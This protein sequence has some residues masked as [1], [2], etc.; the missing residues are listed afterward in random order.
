MN[1]Y[2]LFAFSGLLSFFAITSC[3]KTETIVRIETRID[4]LQVVAKDTTFSMNIVNW[5]YFG[6][7]NQSFL[8]AGPSTYVNTTDGIKFFGQAAR[9]GARLQVKSEVGFKDKTIYYKW[10]TN[11]AGQF[12]DVVIGIKYVPTSMEGKPPIQ[13]VDL[14]YYSTNHSF[15]GSLLVQ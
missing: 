1:R 3:T 4:T 6:L 14:E 10:K 2:C 8:S 12:S 13:G 11:G 5:D 9:Y 15:E 7:L